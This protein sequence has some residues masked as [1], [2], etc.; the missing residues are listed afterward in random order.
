MESIWASR[1]KLP[2]FPTI[3]NDAIVDVAVIGAGITGIA[4]AYLLKQSGTR[5]ALIERGTCASADTAATSA[6]LVTGQV[7]SDPAESPLAEVQTQ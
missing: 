2:L 5:V 4:A 6:H 7:H 1:S 3:A